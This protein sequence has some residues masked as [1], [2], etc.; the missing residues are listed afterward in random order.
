[1]AEHRAGTETRRDL[2]KKAAV[3]AAVTWVAPTVM[4][5]SAAAQGGSGAPSLSATFEPS[6]GGTVNALVLGVGLQPGSPVYWGGFGLGPDQL[7][8][9]VAGDGTFSTTQSI[10]CSQFPV[11]WGGTSAGGVGIDTLS[12]S[13]SQPT[14]LCA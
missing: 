11:Q 8:G 6:H 12:P 13:Y 10:G 1:M 3:G 9:A 2:L 7:V 4:S 5:S 14:L